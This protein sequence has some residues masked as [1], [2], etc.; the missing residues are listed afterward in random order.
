MQFFGSSC[1]C[2]KHPRATVLAFAEHANATRGRTTAIAIY[3]AALALLGAKCNDLAG[4]AGTGQ[5]TQQATAA[6]KTSCNA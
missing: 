5:I 3:E 2:M 1:A 4:E 6:T